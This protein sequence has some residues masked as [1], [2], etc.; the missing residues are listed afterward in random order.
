MIDE[1]EELLLDSDNEDED[2]YE[3]GDNYGA[4]E[5]DDDMEERM[6][7]Q[8][9]VPDLNLQG[10]IAVADDQQLNLEALKL[11]LEDIGVLSGCEFFA[12]GQQVFDFVEETMLR[13]KSDPDKDNRQPIRALLLDFQMPK[14]NGLDVIARV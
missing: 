14:M 4:H 2:E 11:N 13:E 5:G 12:D 8:D 1:S 3:D 7:D 10:K 9:K 6:L